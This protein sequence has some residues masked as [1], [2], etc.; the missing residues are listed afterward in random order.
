[1]VFF[2]VRDGGV[3]IH[4]FQQALGDDSRTAFLSPSLA[5]V[6]SGE[7]DKVSFPRSTAG[8]AAGLLTLRPPFWWRDG[9]GAAVLCSGG[10][11][12]RG[13]SP[14]G[15]VK[16]VVL[17]SAG[18]K[19]AGGSSPPRWRPLGCC[20]R[21]AG[22]VSSLF[23]RFG[24]SWSSWWARRCGGGDR[25]LEFLSL[26][27][28][29]VLVRFLLSLPWRCWGCGG[30]GPA[31]V[32]GSCC[33]LY[34]RWP[35]FSVRPWW[36]GE[37]GLRF[38]VFV[39]ARFFSGRPWWR[40][41]MRRSGLLVSWSASPAGFGPFGLDLL[42]VQGRWSDGGGS[43]AGGRSSATGAG[44]R[45]RAFWPMFVHRFRSR[46][47]TAGGSCSLKAWRC[48]PFQVCWRPAFLSSPGDA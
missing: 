25:L 39:A 41:G 45:L 28:F 24:E 13:R 14:V 16:V 7:R 32:V 30:A 17:V 19:G 15:A 23:W 37:K 48:S 10:V 40:G 4:E 47:S 1:M 36:R 27:L 3:H 20:R 8:E 11:D 22:G 12:S 5:T 18:N 26:G 2:F 38:L 33:C 29:F 34:R 31:G 42:P 6:Q 21:A 46:R 44:S 35:R 43:R 9:G